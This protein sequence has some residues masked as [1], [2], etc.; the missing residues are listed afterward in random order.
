MYIILKKGSEII[1]N[2][3]FKNSYTYDKDNFNNIDEDEINYNYYNDTLKD[4]QDIELLKIQSQAVLILMLGYYFEYIAANQ[5]IE[6]IEARI[7]KRNLDK[8]SGN[9]MPED[10]DFE[11][12]ERIWKNKGV[13]SDK[14]AL[15]AAELELYGQIFITNI[16]Y[17]KL[18]RLS[19]HISARD[20]TLVKTAN[21]EIF[22]ASVFELISYILNYKGVSILFNISNEDDPNEDD[23]NN[24]N[25]NE[26]APD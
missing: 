2:E 9:Y 16:N 26:Y 17:I 19:E 1:D 18:Q 8:A 24:D 23:K 13:D 21:N 6:L 14:T 4:I 10:E 3:N 25:P 15:I 12:Q 22:I 7:A 20:L 11:A 5:A